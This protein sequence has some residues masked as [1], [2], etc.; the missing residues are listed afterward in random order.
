MCNNNSLFLC[1]HNNFD[2][3]LLWKIQLTK[4]KE[5][6]VKGIGTVELTLEVDGKFKTVNLLITL[7]VLELHCNLISTGKATN[8]GRMVIMKK[9]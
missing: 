9:I 1:I 6:D 5:L 3:K 2:G 7:Y 4:E 8:N